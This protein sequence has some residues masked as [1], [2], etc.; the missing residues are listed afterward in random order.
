MTKLCTCCKQEKP[1]TEFT[2]RK[3]VYKGVERWGHKS[4][5]KPCHTEAGRVARQANLE[6]AH[7][8]EKEL[9][10]QRKLN[11]TPE[12]KEELRLK[13]LAWSKA[14]R[15]ANPD[16][17]KAKKLRHRDREIERKRERYQEKKDELRA[18][19]REYDK[20]HRKEIS[21]RQKQYNQIP[22]VKA[23]LKAYQ[24]ERRPQ[25]RIRVREKIRNLDDNYIKTIIRRNVGLPAHMQPKQL[26][27]AQKLIIKI[28]RELR[29]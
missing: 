3:F 24:Q 4:H 17:V 28:K 25:D 22:E 21:E 18:K 2:R 13:F 1:L 20:L 5:C 19:C 11:R 15:D 14:W 27:E 29:S 12:Q 26:I 9:R 10:E 8:R 7:V 6:K 16:K 23:R